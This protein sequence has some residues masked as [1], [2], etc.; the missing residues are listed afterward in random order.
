MLIAGPIFALIILT[1]VLINYQQRRELYELKDSA[2]SIGTTVGVILIGSVSKTIAFLVMMVVYQYRVI[3]QEIGI[4]WYFLILFF[5]EDFT[6]YWHHR[7][8]HELRV[9]WAAHVNHHSS[10]KLNYTVAIRQSWVE[11]CYRYI[12][13]LWLPLMGFHPLHV[14][15]FQSF[16]AIFQF[17]PHTQL[18]RK[19]G[20][21][22]WIFNTPSHHRVHHSSNTIYLDRNH[23][24]ILIIWD[25]M[26]G[27]FQVELDEEPCVY[28]LT[29]NIDT[30]N[31]LKFQALGYIDLWK[32]V[33]RA[34]K[35]SDKLKYIFKPPGWSHD[36]PDKTSDN[37][38]RLAKEAK[39]G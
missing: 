28:G 31:P 29:N 2:A 27:T 22:E 16:N 9:L 30:F 5:A 37:L 25:R 7:L 21:I 34:D 18:I 6:F 10:Q 19:V 3:D 32:D 8:S 15:L 1:E 4:W 33:S 35:L 39:I 38:R 36:G 24:G 26:F 17:W 14:L 23:A 12:F 20:F 11:V 13:W